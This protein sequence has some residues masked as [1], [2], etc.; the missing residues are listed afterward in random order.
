MRG[1]RLVAL[2]GAGFCRAARL[3]VKS[4]VVGETVLDCRWTTFHRCVVKSTR[5]PLHAAT[6]TAATCVVKGTRANGCQ[7]CR[8]E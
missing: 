7:V 2:G 5:D 3:V 4:T 1:K 8:Q 6:P